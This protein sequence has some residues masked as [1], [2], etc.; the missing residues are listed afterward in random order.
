MARI[1]F[2]LDGTL[3]DSAP[4]IHATANAVLAEDGHAPISLEQARGFVGNGVAVFI[5]KMRAVRDI[6]ASAQDRLKSR[7]MARY[8]DAVSL[9]R[10]YPAVPE[11]LSALKQRG[12]RL[13]ICTNKPAGPAKAVLSHLRLDGHFDTVIG[14]DTMPLHKPDPAPL[15]AAFAALGTGAAIYVGDSEVD[16]E[17]ARR[18]A[19]PLLLFTEGYRKTSV[20]E[21]PHAA[22]F[23][24]FSTLAGLIEDVIA[25]LGRA[26][27]AGELTG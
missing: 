24:D 6:P 18:A 20:E 9:T 1:V 21:L 27:P 4:D 12:H 8:D 22:S 25:G 23:S 15:H 16:A 7:F 17:T 3:I 2:D 11:A 10:P 13:G 14:G 26:G 5:E 19:L